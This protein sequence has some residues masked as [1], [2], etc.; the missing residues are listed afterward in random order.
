[1]AWRVDCDK[2]LL[3]SALQKELKSQQRLKNTTV[4]PAFVPIIERDIAE[5]QKGLGSMSEVK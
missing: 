1:M 3:T 5:L 4:Q 2:A